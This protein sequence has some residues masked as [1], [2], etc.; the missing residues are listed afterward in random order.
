[1]LAWLQQLPPWLPPLLWL[2]GGGTLGAGG[3]ELAGMGQQQ[4]PEPPPGACVQQ[5]AQLHAVTL[6]LAQ[7]LSTCECTCARD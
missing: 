2:A 6:E 4:H 5:V 1:M 3:L 7:H